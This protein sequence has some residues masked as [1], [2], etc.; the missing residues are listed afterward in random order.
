MSKKPHPPKGTLLE[1]WGRGNLRIHVYA[2]GEGGTYSK[3]INEDPPP[4]HRAKRISTGSYIYRGYR[5][6]NCGY[7]QPDHC[8]WWEASDEKGAAFHAT[9]KRALIAM[10]DEDLAGREK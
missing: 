7:H 1:D 10:I 4:K 2:D 8:V 3:A 5:L 6:E 9:T